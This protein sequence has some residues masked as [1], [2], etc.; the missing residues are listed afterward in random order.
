[1]CSS[2]SISEMGRLAL[3][4]IL[5]ILGGLLR[6]NE[7][8]ILDLIILSLS[9]TNRLNTQ[10]LLEPGLLSPSAHMDPSSMVFAVGWARRHSFRKL[11]SASSRLVLFSAF[12]RLSPASALTRQTLDRLTNTIAASRGMIRILQGLDDG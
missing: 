6:P 4:T 5:D 1:M 10:D 3:G 2:F 7:S 12:A 11:S 8:S 9:L